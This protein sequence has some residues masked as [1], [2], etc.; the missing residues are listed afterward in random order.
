MAGTSGTAG[1]VNLVGE[2][3]DLGELLRKAAD[4]AGHMGAVVPASDSFLL[5]HGVEPWSGPRSL[6]LWIPEPHSGGF[7]SHPDRRARDLGLLRRPLQET[8][9]DVLVD[10]LARGLDRPRIAGLTR[11]AEQ[12]LLSRLS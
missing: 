2:R 11:A 4:A 7:G 8:L 9:Q 6:P 12:D 10:E 5:G 3:T 1:P